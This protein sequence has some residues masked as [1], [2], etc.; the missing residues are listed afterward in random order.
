MTYPAHATRLAV[1]ATP[2]GEPCSRFCPFLRDCDG[3]QWRGGEWLC[4]VCLGPAPAQDAVCEECGAEE[5]TNLATKAD[6]T[7]RL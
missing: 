2:R 7:D 5:A 4:Q 1:T 6:G 3:C